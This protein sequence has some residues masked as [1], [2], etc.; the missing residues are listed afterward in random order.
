MFPWPLETELF[1]L[2]LQRERC[3][4]KE[5]AKPRSFLWGNL[6]PSWDVRLSGLNPG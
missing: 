4:R 6:L 1:Y 2:K 5:G 3:C